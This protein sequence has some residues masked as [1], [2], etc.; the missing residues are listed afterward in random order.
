M[1]YILLIAAISGILASIQKDHNPPGVDVENYDFHTPAQLDS[2]WR[3]ET[4]QL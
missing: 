3:A 1:R 4:G 2:L